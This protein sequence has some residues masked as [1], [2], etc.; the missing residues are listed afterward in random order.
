MLRLN[1]LTNDSLPAIASLPHI[2]YIDLYENRLTYLS[3]GEEPFNTLKELEELD[4]S[5]NELRFTR[6]LHGMPK[7]KKLYLIEN[8][9]T[10]IDPDDFNDMP[11]LEMLELGSN[12]LRKIEH[13]DNI[14][15]ITQLFLG[16]NKITRIENLGALK[17]LRL[18][19]LQSNRI[20]K[21][22]N[23]DELVNLEEL[24]LSHNG[25]SQI[26]NLDKLVNLK[27]LDLAGNRL[28]V[29]KNIA[30]LTKLVDLWLNNNLIDSDEAL[31]ESLEEIAKLPAL[32][33]L[34]LEQNPICTTIGQDEYRRTVLRAL[35]RLQQLDA[36]YV[37]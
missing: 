6:G 16:R 27:T 8:K 10:R 18:L 31:E 28:K 22:E 23:L 37:E 30:H 32:E 26:E 29:I 34:Y 21:I 2:K 12:R 25:I 24:Y 1:H 35:P 4:L 36:D 33:T 5:F 7:L 11:E 20:V 13:L 3:P 9:I 17:N 19:N 15:T 14:P